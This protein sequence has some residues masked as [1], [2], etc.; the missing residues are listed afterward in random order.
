ML[1]TLSFFIFILFSSFSLAQNYDFIWAT[2]GGG[3]KDDRSHDLCIDSEGNILVT[4]QFMETAIFDG[5]EIVHDGVLDALFLVKYNPLGEI[6]WIRSSIGPGASGGPESGRTMGWA[7]KTDKDDNIYVTGQYI[8]WIDLDGIILPDDGGCEEF[9]IAKYDKN[10]TILWA[11]HAY[12]IYMVSGHDLVIDSNDDVIVTGSYGHHNFSGFADFGPVR[13]NSPGGNQIFYAKYDKNGNF[14][15]AKDAGSPIIGGQ[16]RGNG[17]TIDDQD[18]FLVTGNFSGIANFDNIQ[19]TCRGDRDVF[20][21]KYNSNN[22]IEWVKTYGG[23]SRDE[24]L[25]VLLDDVNHVYVTGLFTDNLIYDNGQVQGIGDWDIFLLKCDYDGNVLWAKVAGGTGTDAGQKITFDADGN[26]YLIGYFENLATFENIQ[27]SS[28]N[29][30]ASFLAKYNTDGELIW[31]QSLGLCK[32]E[33]GFGIQSNQNQNLVL[34]AHFLETITLGQTTLESAGES[35]VLIAEYGLINQPPI[36]S[37]GN[38]TT[39]LVCEEVEFDG[40]ESTDPDGNIVEYLWDFGDGS[41][42]AN[43]VIVSHT[44]VEGIYQVTL[45]VVDAAGAT[46]TDEMFV[47]VITTIEKIDQLIEYIKNLNLHKGTENSLVSKLE[48]AKKSIEKENINAAI[49]QLGAFI[50]NLQAQSGK[51]ISQQD[52]DYLIAQAERIIACLEHSLAKQ[53]SDQNMQSKTVTNYQLL[54]NFPNPFNPT[55]TIIYSLQ[56][57]NFVTL[58]IY[59][60]KGQKVKTLSSTIKSAGEHNAVWNGM[61]DSGIFLPSGLYFCKMTVGDFNKTISMLLLK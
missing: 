54:G 40:S 51:K 16:E 38:D 26:L 43:G 58:D 55:T 23:N 35:D 6:L 45:T 34:T 25:D 10:G 46:A 48:T 12:G 60:C 7:V 33:N 30:S 2:S 53:T 3:L 61:D 37:A 8:G 4:G 22:N 41:P 1:K 14:I 52:A 29:G 32:K 39:I 57:E 17:I 9:F 15:W 36:A 18:N 31:V 20:L 19:V 27:I 24:S 11:K 21:A 56:E 59:N 44:F 28:S 49:N 50:N 13:L 5:L 47:T 42:V